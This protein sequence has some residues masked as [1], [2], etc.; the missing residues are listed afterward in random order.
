MAIMLAADSSYFLSPTVAAMGACPLIRTNTP[1]SRWRYTLPS[2]A[3]SGHA[4]PAFNDACGTLTFCAPP[5][6]A[7]P[8]RQCPA[9]ARFG[10]CETRSGPGFFSPV[11]MAARASTWAVFSVLAGHNNSR[12]AA[13]GGFLLLQQLGHITQR[14]DRGAQ[15]FIALCAQRRPS[16]LQ[17]CLQFLDRD[18][19]PRGALWL[20]RPH[21]STPCRN[22][23]NRGVSGS[24]STSLIDR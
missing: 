17:P 5:Y 19:Q 22:L 6:A 3:V 9:A 23:R 11:A 7:T 12:S 14:A 18:I 16:P 21:A 20:R 10:F 2:Q 13:R 4:S 15:L 8:W 24:P 1:G